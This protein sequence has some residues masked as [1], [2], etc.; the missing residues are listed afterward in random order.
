MNSKAILLAL[1]V[2]GATGGLQA[3]PDDAAGG[4]PGMM[5]GPGGDMMGGGMP[6]MGGAFGNAGGSSSS[7]ANGDNDIVG[8]S[9][10]SGRTVSRVTLA[11]PKA[12]SKGEKTIRLNF[13]NAP[14]NQVLNYMSDAAGYIIILESDVSSV[15]VDVWSNQALSKDE[16]VA[17]LNSVLNS[18]GYGV[19]QEERFLT[20]VDKND[21]RRLPIPIK[22][23]ND[24]T[25]IPRDSQVVTQIIPVRS[26]TAS[27]LIKDLSPLL[28]SDTTVTANESAN[29][30]VMTDTQMNIH[31]VA[32]IIK[33][34]DSVS[35]SLNSIKVYPLTYADSKSVVAILKELFP[36]QDSSTSSAAGGNGRGGRGGGGMA[37]MMGMFGM[38]GNTGSTASSA[39]KASTRIT[40]VADENGNTV[41]ASAPDDILPLIE[42]V[43]A[44]IDVNMDDESTAQVFRL[45]NADP[46]EM[47]NLIASLYPSDTTSSSSGFGGRGGGMMGMVMGGGTSSSTGKSD[48]AKRKAQVLAVADQRTSS[49]VVT[50][51]KSVMPSIAHL[52]TQLDTDPAKKMKVYV[53][54]L[55]NAEVADVQTV[56]NDLFQST[57]SRSS[58]S[59]STS[60]DALASRSQSMIQS[61]NQST[62][63]STRSSSS[64]RSSY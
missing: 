23:G 55:Q 54:N 39:Q 62:S 2:S 32:E 60:T 28:P 27:Q 3:Q 53:Y 21:A 16:A 57:S 38:G 7:S 24:P 22:Q 18:K 52:V 34:L 10:N 31:R 13:R 56:L 58:S 17:L 59:T 12:N 61:Q 36:S 30:L 1:L 48:R 43:I 11:T 29:A 49:V 15:N 26:L 6:D 5:G 37:G 46:T 40:I 42:N 50:A 44:S 8:R 41:I 4:G 20:V 33:A 19:I 47:A 25:N 51:D 63:S 45:R 64:S 9:G 14:L 35:T